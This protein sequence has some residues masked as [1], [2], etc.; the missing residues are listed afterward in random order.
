MQKSINGTINDMQKTAKATKA[1]K[2]TTGS[3]LPKNE[4]ACVRLR[5]MG[6]LM[7]LASVLMALLPMMYSGVYRYVA[8]RVGDYMSNLGITVMILSGFII[9]L[10]YFLLGLYTIRAGERNTRLVRGVYQLNN[11]LTFL[12]I[13]AGVLLFLPW[14]VPTFKLMM[15]H[16]ATSTYIEQGIVPMFIMLFVDMAL[17]IGLLASITGVSYTC[18]IDREKK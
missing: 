14:P 4:K 8:A 18:L 13:V 3:T 11:I 17:I 2:A 12:A 10:L 5:L 7:A 16:M 1:H 9:A 15:T 6:A